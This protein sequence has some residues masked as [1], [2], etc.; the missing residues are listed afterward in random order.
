MN[1]FAQKVWIYTKVIL[2]YIVKKVLLVAAGVAVLDGLSFLIFKGFTFRAL[3]E[4]MAWTGIAFMLITG[5]LIFGATTGGRDYGVPGQFV[6]SAHVQNIIDFNI[7]I[8]KN[9]ESKFD[10]RI[11]VFLVGLVVFALGALVQ[12]IFKV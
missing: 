1:E 8:R 9:I 7:E 11:Q 4:R 2:L 5:I 6:R 10:F 3:S 12:V